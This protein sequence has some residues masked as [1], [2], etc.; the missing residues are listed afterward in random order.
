M[1]HACNGHSKTQTH[2]CTDPFFSDVSW[3][4]TDPYCYKFLLFPLSPDDKMIVM[5][6]LGASSTHEN[7]IMDITVLFT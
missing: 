7:K 6:T 2:T 5:A 4:V 1:M 3:Q